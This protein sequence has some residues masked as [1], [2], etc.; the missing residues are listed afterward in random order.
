VPEDACGG[1][2]SRTEEPA[3]R[4]VEA[5]G[6]VTTSLVTL[7]MAL[8]PDATTDLGGKAFGILQSLRLA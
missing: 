6:G 8:A 7:V 4:Q 2:S 1:F 3:F 5:A